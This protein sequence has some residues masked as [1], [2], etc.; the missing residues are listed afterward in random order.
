MERKQGGFTLIE[1]LTVVAII[2]LLAGMTIGAGRY[3]IVRSTIKAAEAQ[4]MAIEKA[5]EAYALDKRT[6][7]RPQASVVLHP[8]DYDPEEF[9]PLYGLKLSSISSQ[10]SEGSLSYY[11]ASLAELDVNGDNQ[12]TEE[13]KF[14]NEYYILDPWGLP[15][16]FFTEERQ[17]NVAGTTFSAW[18]GRLNPN[19]CDLASRGPDGLAESESGGIMEGKGGD[20]IVN[21]Q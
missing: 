13:D 9:Q 2:L 4:L 21:W 10:Y 18:Y 5:L 6:Y 20:D 19:G 12:L 15:I 16:Y 14:E 8:E 7:P 11:K 17:I 1:L 3:M